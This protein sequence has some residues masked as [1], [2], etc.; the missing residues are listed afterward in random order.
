[1]ARRIAVFTGSRAE[2]GLLVP[3]LRAIGAAPGLELLLIAGGAHVAGEDEGFAVAAQVPIARADETPGS[4]PRAIGAGIVAVTDA[5]ER[6]APDIVLV[7][8]DRFEAFAA[9]VAATQM[10]LPTAHVE[11]GDLTQG[12]TLDDV[13]RHAMTKLAH[14]HLVTNADAAER[15]RLMGEEPW[16]IYDVG[17][18]TIDL[19]RAGEFAPPEA[20]AADLGIDLARPLV[21]FTQHPVTTRPDAAGEEIAASLAAL[22][23]ARAE[24]GAEMVLTWPN[25]DLGSAA[26]VA[27]LEAFVLSSPGVVLRRSLGRR[28]YHGLLDVAG[29]VTHGVCVGNSSSGVKE[30]PAFGCPAVDIG[31]RQAGRLRGANAVHVPHE[32]GAIFAA[33]RRALTDDAYRAEVAA[34]PNPYGRG[35]AGERVA[36]ILAGLDLGDPGLLAKQTILPPGPA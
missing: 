18:P 21:V 6:L 35:E 2:F 3:I 17:F 1:M 26:I 25:G 33:I 4:T 34:A 29:R 19:I 13:V 9:L 27:A 10:G 23:R 24:L 31:N 32:A 22:D 16:R 7:Y 14:V 30:T 20:V 15:V 12:G 5:L 11:G 8:G 28:L 36:R